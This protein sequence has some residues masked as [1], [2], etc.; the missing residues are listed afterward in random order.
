MSSLCCL[1][2]LFH[3][4]P[5]KHGAVLANSVGWVLKRAQ[6]LTALSLVLWLTHLVSSSCSFN[7]IFPQTA[8]K[9]PQ[10]LTD[11]V[12]IRRGQETA[13]RLAARV[14]PRSSVAWAANQ[15]RNVLLPLLRQ[16]QRWSMVFHDFLHLS[17]GGCVEGDKTV[18]DCVCRWFAFFLPFLP[19]PPHT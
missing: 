6:A 10:C 16:V 4:S 15:D 18:G 8:P 19:F 1:S 7:V 14:T 2:A 11:W 17:V 3:N 9:S 12:Q 13:P 5:A